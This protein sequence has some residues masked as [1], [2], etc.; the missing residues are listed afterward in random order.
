MEPNLFFYI[1]LVI[2]LGPSLSIFIIVKI[3]SEVLI[4]FI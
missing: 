4:A 1:I 2:L 3:E